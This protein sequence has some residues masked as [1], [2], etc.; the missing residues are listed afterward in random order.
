[1]HITNAFD[2]RLGRRFHLAEP[3][4]LKAKFFFNLDLTP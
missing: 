4:Y 1:M 3:L 2:N